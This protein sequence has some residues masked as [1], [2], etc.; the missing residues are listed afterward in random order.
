MIKYSS[1]TD[2]PGSIS[3]KYQITKPCQEIFYSE[4]FEVDKLTCYV[5]S[6]E[7]FIQGAEYFCEVKT[8]DTIKGKIS[9]VTNDNLIME[10]FVLL[11]RKQQTETL[12]IILYQIEKKDKFKFFKEIKRIKY[13]IEELG[14]HEIDGIKFSL[15]INEDPNNNYPEHPPVIYP[16]RFIH[17]LIEECNF[18]DKD[19][20]KAFKSTFIKVSLNKKEKSKEKR[21]S[22]RT[23]IIF[24]EQ[25]PKFRY[26]FHIP[27]LSLKDDIIKIKVYEYNK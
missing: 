11:C 8:V 2:N 15:Q 7:N 27:L 4:K 24:N 10:K 6:F 22:E 25:N 20:P 3:I 12:E 18:I 23:H 26:T 21:Y 13:L 16:K 9:K 5:Q 14:E 19:F 1:L 17:L